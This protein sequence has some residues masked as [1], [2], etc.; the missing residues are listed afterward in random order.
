MSHGAWDATY[1]TACTAMAK[2]ANSLMGDAWY[3]VRAG[4]L[5]CCKNTWACFT[6]ASTAAGSDGR[7]SGRSSNHCGTRSSSGFVPSRLGASPKAAK[8]TSCSWRLQGP[9]ALRTKSAASEASTIAAK[10]SPSLSNQNCSMA[11]LPSTL[12]VVMY[13]RMCCSQ[14]TLCLPRFA[15]RYSTVGSC[16]PCT[17]AMSMPVM[18]G[19]TTPFP[20][21]AC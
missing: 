8:V 14:G 9:F 3:S 7:H 4:M 13:E 17:A 2:H 20:G 18:M 1:C 15:N 19:P 21:P 10:K 12:A 16:P 6:A 11:A 5:R